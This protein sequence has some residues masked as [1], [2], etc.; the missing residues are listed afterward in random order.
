M[1]ESYAHGKL[2]ISGEYLVLQGALALAVPCAYGQKT[3]FL[4]DP[5][6]PPGI[7][8]VSKDAQGETWFDGMFSPDDFRPGMFSLG[9]TISEDSGIRTVE[10]IQLLLRACRNLKPDFLQ[11][12]IAVTI[13]ST[14]EFPL[15]WGLGSSSTLTWNI[16][17]LA[18]VDPFA[19][20]KA[21]SKGSGFDIACAGSDMPLLFR[22]D[23]EGE[24]SDTVHF[25]PPE[26]DNLFFVH[27]NVKQDSQKE[28]ADFLANAKDFT[29][30]TDI[31]SEISEA[32]LFCDDRNDFMQLLEEHEEVMQYV[33][34]E[35]KIQSRMFADYDGVVKS[36]GA[37]GG[38]FVLA[39][40]RKEPDYTISY[41]RKKGLE[42]AI[43]YPQMI[44]HK[45]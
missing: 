9:K 18:G 28:V 36:L 26:P 25:D 3:R 43:P 5:D 41:F 14:L 34:Q 6:G 42:T 7:R 19:L 39:A 35:E 1:R 20:H 40:G 8:W 11:R 31:I 23:A 44:F 17:K 22:R 37:W 2:L 4:H 45:V 30:E 24:I 13:E 29:R 12:E 15:G 16:A 33:L 32:L 27:L 10:M 21:V 38:D